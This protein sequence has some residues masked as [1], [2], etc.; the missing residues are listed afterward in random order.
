M[1]YSVLTGLTLAWS[2]DEGGAAWRWNA[3][4]LLVGGYFGVAAACPSRV[5]APLRICCIAVAAASLV[6]AFLIASRHG[7]PGLWVP[8]TPLE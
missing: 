6:I 5:D 4:G 8:Q 3:P 2:S 7:A 1:L